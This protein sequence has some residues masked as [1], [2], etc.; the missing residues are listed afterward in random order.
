GNR[1]ARYLDAAQIAEHL[2]ACTRAGVQGGFHVIGDAAVAEIVTGFESAAKQVGAPA[3]VAGRHRLEHLEM[4]DAGQ[5]R[6]LA[7]LGVSASMQPL[8]D[9]AWGGTERAYATRLGLPRGARLNPFATVT[10]AGMRLA[11][12]SDVPVTPI[13]PWAA[14][15]AAVHH[16][17]EGLGIPPAAAF[18]A[19]TVGG[20]QAA[21]VDDGVTGA[22]IVGAPANYAIWDTTDLSIEAG[23]PVLERGGALPR[24]LRTV[25]RGQQI[26]DSDDLGP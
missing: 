8:F 3:L 22:L 9:D 16:R 25:L 4:V 14:V 13:G 21:G 19:H 24:C 20:W 5:V 18:D 15:L 6:R 17:T 2:V 12:G 26:Y 23:L 1:G 10:D 11:F 7:A